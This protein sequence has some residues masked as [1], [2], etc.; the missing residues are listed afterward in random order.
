MAGILAVGPNEFRCGK[1][2]VGAMPVHYSVR[3]Q[4]GFYNLRVLTKHLSPVSRKINIH[5]KFP[6][7][8]NRPRPSA[9]GHLIGKRKPPAQP[10]EVKA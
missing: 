5:M 6:T 8:K 10:V 1:V 7:W 4:E 3:S 9:A 2:F